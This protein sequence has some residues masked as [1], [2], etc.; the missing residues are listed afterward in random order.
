[1]KGMAGTAQAGNAG[2][3]ILQDDSGWNPELVESLY[4]LL[5]LVDLGSRD[6][7]PQLKELERG[8][9]DQVYSELIYL[10]SHLR[11]TASEA[12]DH[13]RRIVDHRETMQR[14]MGVPV[15]LRVA[16]V[17]YFVE[18]N[19]QLKNP[20]IIELKVFEQTQASVYRDE[21]T[22]LCNYRYFREH[23]AREIQRS[24]RYSAP[25]SLVMIDIDSFKDYNDKQGHESGNRALV[26]IAGLLSESLRKIDV[27][28]R[29]GGEEFA[30]ILASTSKTGAIHV[31]ER[32]RA[33]I[34]RHSFSR[35]ARHG[36]RLTVS[37]GVA[38]F[39]ADALGAG[40]LVRRADS[41]LYVAKTLGKNQVHMYGEN[42]R[43]H[44]RVDVVLEGRL[45]V[46]ADTHYPL[47]TINL[48]E[49]GF[50]AFTKQNLPV[51]SLVQVS[52]TLPDSDHE[53]AASGRI[54]RVVAKSGGRYETAIRI[55]D[56]QSRDQSRLMKYLR[57]VGKGS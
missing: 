41:A 53:V 25:L 11:Y 16:L 39:P 13:W 7:A 46:L 8:S 50:L 34:E 18:V 40:E 22:G 10:L 30:L 35:G 28:A 44:G 4:K 52:L 17:S 29:Y 14:R 37:M 23:L 43:S 36:R 24:E 19:R 26:A 48:S 15:D 54:I 12:R 20:K 57:E 38:T 21:L 42:R 55:V 5:Y 56:I 1:M 31:A 51:G 27:A 45:S 9:G 49:G 32:T 6:L 3:P 47:T 2:A 33:R